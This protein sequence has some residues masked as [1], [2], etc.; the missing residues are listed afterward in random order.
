MYQYA[1]MPMCQLAALWHTAWQ[2]AHW[3]IIQLAH[4]FIATLVPVRLTV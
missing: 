2:L 4:Y 1:N 3:H